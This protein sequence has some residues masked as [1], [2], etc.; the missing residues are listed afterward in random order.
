MTRSKLTQITPVQIETF[1]STMDRYLKEAAR[2]SAEMKAQGLRTM[3][4][5]NVQSL[6][7]S[8]VR[9]QAGIKGLQ[10][11]FSQHGFPDPKLFSQKTEAE[12]LEE[13]RSAQRE[14]ELAERSL[15]RAHTKY[16]PKG[17]DQKKKKA[18]DG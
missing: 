2:I 4:A 10:A 11:A 14:G 1:V 8:L 17:K 5:H 12:R 16:G 3:L 15:Q 7:D 9:A 6:E 18:N 13:E